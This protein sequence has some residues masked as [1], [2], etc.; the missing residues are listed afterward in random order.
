MKYWL[1]QPIKYIRSSENYSNK[2]SH[3]KDD[4]QKSVSSRKTVRQ[5]VISR[6]SIRRILRNDSRLR[7]NKIQIELL[8][9]NEHKEKRMNFVNRI[10]TSFQEEN[11]MRIL[12]SD[13]KM[14]DIDGI[15][16]S[17]NDRIWAVNRSAADTERWY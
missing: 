8:L 13:E 10:Q 3:T 17:Q 6:T 14:F 15:Y 2:R 5:L 7:V 9:A 11:T 4:R 1:Y 12:F 16:N